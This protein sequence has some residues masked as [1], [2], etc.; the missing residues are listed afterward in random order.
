MIVN[1]IYVEFSKYYFIVPCDR[2]CRSKYP[3]LANGQIFFKFLQNLYLGQIDARKVGNVE[4]FENPAPFKLSM[5]PKI[6]CV[7]FFLKTGLS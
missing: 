7:Y 3:S 4:T 5:F 2:N 1:K 6:C